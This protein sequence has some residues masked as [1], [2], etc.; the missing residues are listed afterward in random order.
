VEVLS[1]DVDEVLV[2]H[3][4][5]VAHLRLLG[6]FADLFADLHLVFRGEETRN[7][8]GVDQVVDVLE[9]AFLDNLSVREQEADLLV[10]AASRPE[11]CPDVLM[12]FFLAITLRDFDLEALHFLHA[13]TELGHR[14]AA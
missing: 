4:T 13:C 6:P 10:V 9:E 14:A 11:K 1:A 3:V 8:S 7:L 5:I 2:D 12:V